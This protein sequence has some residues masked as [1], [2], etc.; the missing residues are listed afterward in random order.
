MPEDTFMQ[1]GEYLLLRMEQQ[2]YLNSF[3]ETLW[4]YV[5]LWLSFF[6]W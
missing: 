4:F 2:N 1:V 6:P 5:F 3:G